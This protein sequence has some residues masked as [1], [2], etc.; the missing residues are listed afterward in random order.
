MSRK[1]LDPDAE[2]WVED[3]HRAEDQL[4]I[5]ASGNLKAGTAAQRA[6]ALAKIREAVGQLVALA[7]EPS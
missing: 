2:C 7:G 3:L 5:V 6:K 4:V 1:A